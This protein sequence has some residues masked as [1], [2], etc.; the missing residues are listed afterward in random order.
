[1]EGKVDP[2]SKVGEPFIKTPVAIHTLPSSLKVIAPKIV[3]ANL[4]SPLTCS[5][6]Q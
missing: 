4:F 5:P 3:P 1:V 6:Q 2:H